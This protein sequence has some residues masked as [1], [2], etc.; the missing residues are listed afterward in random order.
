MFVLENYTFGLQIWIKGF[1]T[2]A[3]IQEHESGKDLAAIWCPAP[4]HPCICGSHCYIAFVHELG[5]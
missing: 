2:S 1:I 4:E 5:S 3:G